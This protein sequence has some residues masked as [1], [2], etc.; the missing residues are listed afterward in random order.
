MPTIRELIAA[1]TSPDGELILLE[2]QDRSL[3]N[4]DQIA[5]GISFTERAG[6]APLRS[7]HSAGGH[8][9]R[10]RREF[11]RGIHALARD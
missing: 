2:Q 7:L 5:E 4:R 6:V 3:W 1:R 11:L 8:C 10:A 9:G